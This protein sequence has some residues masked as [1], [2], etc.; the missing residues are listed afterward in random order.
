MELEDVGC[1]IFNDLPW[2]SFFQDI[3]KDEDG[4]IIECK[5]HDLV[6]DLAQ[7]V[8]VDDCFALTSGKE[9]R[10]PEK[11]RQFSHDRESNIPMS[12][13]KSHTLRTV[14]ALDRDF[15][16]RIPHISKLKYLRG[17]DSSRGP[18]RNLSSFI[19]NLKHLRYLHLSFSNVTTIPKSITRLQ[20]LHLLNVGG[21]TSLYKLPESVTNLQNLQ[22]LN[23]TGCSKLGKLPKQTRKMKQPRHLVISNAP[24]LTCMPRGIGQLTRL[25]TLTGFIVGK[26]YGQHIGELQKLNLRGELS[27]VNLNCVRDAKDA[28][29]AR[30][31]S[32]PHLCSLDLSWRYEV[33]NEK[34]ETWMKF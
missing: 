3:V 21:C 31:M 26:E 7:F 1:E 25:Q 5:T 12:L 16:S 10:I 2:R 23:V 34:Q 30:L 11:I 9:E 33:D 13:Y 19:G 6:H 15:G 22:T 14:L 4:N 20:N 29:E 17:L 18:I 27:I 8:M 32:K 24:S 28:E